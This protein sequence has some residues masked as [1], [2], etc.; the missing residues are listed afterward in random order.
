MHELQQNVILR[1][2]TRILLQK[3]QSHGQ[4]AH[5]KSALSLQPLVQP[6]ELQLLEAANRLQLICHQGSF[7]QFSY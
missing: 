7:L 3:V 4:N 1:K 2:M 6:I 5:S